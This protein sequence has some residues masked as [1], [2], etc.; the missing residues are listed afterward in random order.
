MRVLKIVAVSLGLMLAPPVAGAI[1]GA[2]T[3]GL[4]G[5]PVGAAVGGLTGAMIGAAAE[6]DHARRQS[7][8]P[9]V[10]LGREPHGYPCHRTAGTDPHRLA[11]S[12]SIHRRAVTVPDSVGNFVFGS[13]G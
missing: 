6:A 13:G 2:L 10:D 8:Q 4:A 3:G 7:V 12:A 5:G 11:P 9:A 1:T